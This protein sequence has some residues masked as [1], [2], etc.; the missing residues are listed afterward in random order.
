MQKKEEWIKPGTLAYL[1]NSVNELIAVAFK[2]HS[3]SFKRRKTDPEFYI[4]SY[5]FNTPVMIISKHESKDNPK[6]VDILIDSK[7]GWVWNNELSKDP[8]RD[9]SREDL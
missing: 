1:G 5:R 4:E 3:G 7:I 6:R 2:C 9:A 8:I